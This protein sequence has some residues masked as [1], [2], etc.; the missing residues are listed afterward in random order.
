MLPGNIPGRSQTRKPFTFFF[1]ADGD[2]MRHALSWVV[3]TVILSMVTLAV[4]NY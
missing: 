4:L 1:A 2:D 3:L